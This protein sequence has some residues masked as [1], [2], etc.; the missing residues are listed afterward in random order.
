MLPRALSLVAVLLLGFAAHADPSLFGSG[1]SGFAQD[2][3]EVAGRLV[4]RT[5]D[6]VVL[7]DAQGALHT[8]RLTERTRYVWTERSGPRDFVPGAKVRAEFDPDS[9]QQEAVAVWILA[10]PG[11]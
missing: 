3:A 7:R 10:G 2:G 5:K 6:A 1:G 11:A 8:L 9:A 4:S